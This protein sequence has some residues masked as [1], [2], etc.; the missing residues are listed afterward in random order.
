MKFKFFSKLLVTAIIIICIACTIFGCGSSHVEE[1]L[2]NLVRY[3]ETADKEYMEKALCEDDYE[4]WDDEYSEQMEKVIEEALDKGEVD[5]SYKYDAK[6]MSSSEIA[7]INDTTKGSLAFYDVEMDFTIN[8]G[9]ICTVE[10]EISKGK[11]ISKQT[12][13]VKVVKID[14]KW[15][16]SDCVPMYRAFTAE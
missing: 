1:P 4:I 16:V 2:E 3:F 7:E 12:L 5:I 6:K 13:E 14:G 8:G 10:A 15:Y 9:Y 11:D